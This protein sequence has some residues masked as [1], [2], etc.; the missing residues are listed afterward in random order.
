[1]FLVASASAETAMLTPLLV[2]YSAVKGIS[3]SLAAMVTARSAMNIFIF[4]YQTTPLV[5]L[6]G[7]GYMDMKTC[8][9][10][11]GIMAVWQLIWI[12]MSAPYWNWIM[13]V[14]K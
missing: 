9:R 10:G 11:F 8:L 3:G 14:V 4:P 5:V 7:T 6:W 2:K 13:N 1:H 12:C